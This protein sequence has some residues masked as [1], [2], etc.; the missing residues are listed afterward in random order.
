MFPTINVKETGA[1]IRNIMDKQGITAK[2]IQEYLNLASVQ[3][4]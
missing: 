4:E 1:N 2:D 3:S